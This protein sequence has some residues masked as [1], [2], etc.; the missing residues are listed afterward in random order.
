MRRLLKPV[1]LL[2]VLLIS[3]PFFLL[4][5]LMFGVETMSITQLLSLLVQGPDSTGQ[6]G[7]ILFHIRLP[8]AVLG[9]L[10]GAI[11]GS[12]GAV[13]QG[14]FRNPL[15]DP[16][17]IGVAAGASAGASAM[18]VI[19]ASWLSFHSVVGLPL[20]AC[21]AFAGGLLAV[22]VVYRLANTPEGTSVSTMLLAGIAISALAGAINSLFSFFSDD[23]ML[24]RISIWQMGGLDQANWQQVGLIALIAALL[25]WRLPRESGALNAI[26]LG[27]SEARHL[28]IDVE[29]MKRRLVILTALGVG[30]SVAV[31]GWIAFVGLIVPHVVRLLIGPD[32]RY[33]VPASAL[34]GAALMM[35]ADTLARLVVAP[36]ELP[37][38]V[39][40]ALFGGPFFISLLMQSRRLS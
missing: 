18:I 7:L 15:A 11:F 13:L 37:V 14:L 35:V 2:Q 10:I 8:R 30:C 28:G 17:L 34:L 38:G 29:W 21:G 1:T 39:V 19:G 36:A 25:A 40:T 5:S 23:H 20:V 12:A 4:S 27:E 16:T 33:L 26:L 32:H 6:E 3:L 31:T 22:I 9:L 24:R